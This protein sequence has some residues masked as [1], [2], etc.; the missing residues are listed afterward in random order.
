VDEGEDIQALKAELARLQ[1]ENQRL[2]ELLDVA[3]DFGRLGVWERDP[4]TLTGRW[5]RHMFRFFGFDEGSTPTFAEAAARVHPDDRLDTEFMASLRQPGQ[6]AHRYRVQRPDGSVAHMHSQWRVIAN[7]DGEVE[8]VVGVMVD[9]TEVH[10]LSREA[11][12]ASAQLELALSV[13]DIA[14][15]RYDL[16]TGRIHYDA[17]SQALLQRTVGPE[18][19]TIEAARAWVHPDDL[20][21]VKDAF[22]R[23]LATGGPVDSQL[24]CLRG[25]GQWRTL[26]TRRVLQRDSAGRPVGMIVVG[27]DVTEQQQRTQETLHLARWLE[28]AAEAARIGLWSGPLDGRLPEWNARMYAIVGREPAAGPLRL[29]DALREFAHADDRDRVARETLAWMHGPDDAP[30]ELVMR[31]R[32]PDGSVRWI[33]VRARLEAGADGVRCAFGVM[34]DVTDAREALE[35]LRNAHEQVSLALSSVGMGTWWHDVTTGQ[36]H[37]DAQMYRLRGLD[38][39]QPVPTPEERLALVLPEDRAHVEAASTPFIEGTAPLAYEFRI[40]RADGAVRTLASRSVALTD[41][42]GRVVRRLGVNWDVTESRAAESA[43]R[44]REVALRESRTK[45]ALFSRVSHELRTPLN[46]ISGFTQLLLADQGKVPAEQRQ[47]WL[48]QIQEA[49]ESLLALVDGVLELNAVGDSPLPVALVALDVDALLARALAAVRSDAGARRVRLEAA[50]TAL[51]VVGEER[52]VMQVLT[53]LVAH[54][55][56]RSRPGDAVRVT[57]RADGEEAVI[58]VADAGEPIASAQMATLFEPFGGAAGTLRTSL[59]LALA[60]AQAQRLGGR[61]ALERSDTTGTVLALRLPR[62]AA[63]AESAVA[64][65]AEP[66]VLYVEDNEVN[67]LIVRELLAQRPRLSFHGAVTGAEG[68]AAARRLHPSLVLVDMQLPDMNGLELLKR[69]RADPQTATLPCVALSANA[70]PEDVRAARAAGFDDYWTKPIDLSAFLAAIDR[71][72]PTA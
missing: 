1:A 30:L 11:Q 63:P 42:H 44:D 7:A 5:D 23:T 69:L 39:S 29:G 14:L 15:W 21:E 12:T 16:G 6:H 43:L 37:W 64:P 72:V 65:T 46:A 68:L 47:R 2:H 34:I 60:Q 25:D 56:H 10:R 24:R 52:R 57:C 54:A 8:R 35:A 9:D 26:L 51:R 19:V 3:Q 33:E 38:P 27:L 55:A 58:A 49:G 61:V 71:L 4:R 18:G 48:R 67:M 59:G 22:E 20:P 45:S 28:S 17:R 31:I 53:L 50:P 66:S 41:E 36:D 32:R 40:R 13:S 70:M 62:A